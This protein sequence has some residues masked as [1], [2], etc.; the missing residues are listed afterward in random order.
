MHIFKS[1]LKIKLSFFSVVTTFLITTSS[2]LL[3]TGLETTTVEVDGLFSIFPINIPFTKSEDLEPLFSFTTVVLFIIVFLFDVFTFG[4]LGLIALITGLDTLGE[5]I[6]S[7]EELLVDV[8]DLKL[9]DLVLDLL[10]LLKL[11]ASK[12]YKIL[13]ML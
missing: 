7:V 12:S 6:L 4:V 1:V 13:L 2:S 9:L 11:F 10:E 3:I 8:E 5:D